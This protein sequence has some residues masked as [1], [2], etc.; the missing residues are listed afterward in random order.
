LIQII[1]KDRVVD[2]YVKNKYTHSKGARS[3]FG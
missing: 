1:K 3:K 2:A